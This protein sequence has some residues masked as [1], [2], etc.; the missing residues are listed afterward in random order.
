[1]IL[2]IDTASVAGNENPD[3]SRA[4]TEGPLGFALIRCNF[5]QR[6][7]ADFNRDWPKLKEAGLLRGAYFF[8]RFP[9]NGDAV[10]TPE[11][12][13]RTWIDTLGPLE[14]G[15]LPPALDVE[16]P[17]KGRSETGL[18]AE[19]CLEGVLS[20]HALLKKAY[21]VPPLIYTSARVW[22][23]DLANLPAP[24]LAESPLWLARY[25]F[26][27][28]PA[29]RDTS[30]FEDG[31]LDPPVPP[32]WGDA[33]NWWIHQYQGDAT[34]FPGFPSGKV[35]VNRFNSLRPDATG[36]RVR[37]V[38]RR[39]ALPE[40]G[41]FEATMKTSVRAFQTKRGLADDGAIGPRTFAALC[42]WPAA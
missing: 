18:S 40:T 12:Q 10:P 41:V 13:A 23:D 38:Q 2:G 3:W 8:L 35:D 5:G 24:D 7:D 26:D 14:A 9:R 25:R 28:G 30:V 42:R 22:R 19:T 32:P 31:K 21:G 27:A 20:A 15:D 4:K 37:W 29:M 16:F 34:D 6:P 39:L 17:G 1:M 36:D 11:A 33:T